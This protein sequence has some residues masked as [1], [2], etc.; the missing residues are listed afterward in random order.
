MTT[1]WSEANALVTG[2]TAGVGHA[3]ALQLASEGA[4]VIAH[5][6]DTGRGDTL[7]REITGEC[8]SRWSAY[9]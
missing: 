1:A 6:R 9:H 3:I 5:G 2:A 4:N 8:R 7:V